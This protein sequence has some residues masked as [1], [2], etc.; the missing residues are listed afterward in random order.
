MFQA[1]IIIIEFRAT[2]KKR[3][4]SH[5]KYVIDTINNDKIKLIAK[6][7]MNQSHL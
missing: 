5:F 7:K 4:D 2:N 1:F 6:V 3:Y